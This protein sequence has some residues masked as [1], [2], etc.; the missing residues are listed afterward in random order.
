M[1]RL[2]E[3]IQAERLLLSGVPVG[4]QA[5]GVGSQLGSDLRGTLTELSAMGYSEIELCSFRGFAGDSVRGN[6]G[7]LA[8][9]NPA[10]IRKVIH[11]SDLTARSCH[12]KLAE[13]E[14]GRIAATLD[15]AGALALKYVVII[16][17]QFVAQELQ[18]TFE[19]MNAG[20][21]RIREAGFAMALHTSNDIWSASNGRSIFTEML[22]E[23]APENCIYQLDLSSTLLAGVDPA[24]CLEAHA[25][26][27]FSVHLRDGKKP[28]K[29]VSYLPSLPLGEGEINFRRV[30][31]AGKKA[32][33]TSYIVEMTVPPAEAMEAYKRSAEFITGFNRQEVLMGTPPTAHEGPRNIAE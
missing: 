33:I 15:W 9:M 16:D 14:E 7:V 8:E 23:V 32:G 2:K 30:F 29:P 21:E 18:R 22:S 11:D 6:F 24:D 26:R 25:G 13:F 10:E 17:F 5:I 31:A 20:G 1:A 27:F 28:P 3:R 4:L 12:F 19:L